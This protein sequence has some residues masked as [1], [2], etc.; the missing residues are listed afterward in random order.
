MA[1]RKILQ[2]P[3]ERLRVISDPV[4]VFGDAL[5]SI[6][7]DMVDTIEVQGGAGLAAPQIG[8]AQRVLVIKPK[9]FVEESPDVSYN[10]DYWILINPV[11]RPRGAEQN[12][13]EA[14]LSVPVN[15]GNVLRQEECEVKYQRLDGSENTVTVKWPLS[16]AVQHENDHL[17]GILYV[18]RVGVMERSMIIRR[19]EKLNKHIGR[20][21][22]ARKE[23]DIL[24]LRGPRALAAYRAEKTGK[25][26][27]E[28]KRTKPGKKFGKLKKQK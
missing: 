18:D 14:C 26:M 5:K 7:Q 27:I 22:E 13:P 12:W 23:E 28:R 25:V 17:N 1:S 6:V 4:T 11:V 8:V 2:Y 9:L 3:D 21:A 20:L 24:D 10:S 16:G 19:I 15:S